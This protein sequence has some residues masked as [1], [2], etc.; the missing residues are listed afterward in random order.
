MPENTWVVTT[1]LF[2]HDLFTVVWIGG[3]ITLGLGM[4]PVLRRTLGSGPQAQMIISAFQ[5]RFR[6][7]TSICVV[8]LVV[9]GVLLARR[10]PG[11]TS[12]FA[13][14]DSYSALLSLKHILVIVMVLIVVARSVFLT[15]RVPAGSLGPMG[16]MNPRAGTTPP[17]TRAR[18]A[19]LLL[20]ANIILGIAVLF[21]SAATTILSST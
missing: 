15:P 14:D 10:N 3:M 16:P 6:W 19:M 7:F 11:F 4:V 1:V 18:P 9:T 5:N 13:W 21:L 2:F 12:F 8:G 17:S 20:L